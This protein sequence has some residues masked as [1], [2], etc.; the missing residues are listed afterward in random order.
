ML[1]FTVSSKEELKNLSKSRWFGESISGFLELEC[2]VAY[3]IRC[4]MANLTRGRTGWVFFLESGKW[5]KSS[6]GVAKSNSLSKVSG[7]VALAHLL[8]KDLGECIIKMWSTTE[9][10]QKDTNVDITTFKFDTKNSTREKESFN[11]W[12]LKYSSLFD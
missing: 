11:M 8:K 5:S 4:H 3:F 12:S 6:K 1:V 9:M 2:T 7:M 10:P